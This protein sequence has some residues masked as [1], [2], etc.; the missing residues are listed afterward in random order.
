MRSIAEI[1]TELSIAGQIQ[2]HALR[3]ELA[4]AKTKRIDELVK[5]R[6][7]D[8]ATIHQL[9][10]E[11]GRLENAMKEATRVVNECC[12]KLAEKDEHETS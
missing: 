2:D 3:Q 4:H 12:A 11:V 6:G 1:Q 9:Q 8:A 7:E 5:E 10:S